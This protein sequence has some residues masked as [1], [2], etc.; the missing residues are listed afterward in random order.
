MP[1]PF[2]IPLTK[3]LRTIV[4]LKP[5]LIDAIGV[6]AVHFVDDNFRLQAWQGATTTPWPKRRSKDKG[7]ARALLVQTGAL[8]RSIRQINSAD[9]VTIGTD[10]PYAKI[11]N[12]GGEIR[13][14]Y[15]EVVLSYLGKP[16]ALKLAKTGT[17]SQQRQVTALRRS[18]VYA[19]ITKMPQRQ[20]IGDSPVLTQRCEK[21]IIRKV[22]AAL[23]K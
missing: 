17:E 23:P 11:H 18:S 15:R 9:H 7:A 5:V 12:E 14:K 21:V 13:H 19:H 3:L 10:I 1:N 22:T 6:E 2:E 8:R 20:F 4:E 16:G